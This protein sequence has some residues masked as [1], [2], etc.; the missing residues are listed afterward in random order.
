[1]SSPPLS[2]SEDKVPSKKVTLG[3]TIA[4]FAVLIIVPLLVFTNCLVLS[5]STKAA[6]LVTYGDK[7]GFTS[8]YLVLGALSFV[9]AIANVGKARHSTG[10]GNPLA[11]LDATPV[12]QAAKNILTNTCEQLIFTIIAQLALIDYLS[13]DHV[14]KVIPMINYL[15]VIGRVTY[16][17]GYPHK[18]GFGFQLTAL[19]AMV[20]F[21]AALIFF[22]IKQMF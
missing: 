12:M 13:A 8:R 18:R 2:Q 20:A 15:F 16:L 21:V 17:L 1:M 9:L 22:V 3:L 6:D 14:M 7:L 10:A 19:P 11:G 4:S 5:G